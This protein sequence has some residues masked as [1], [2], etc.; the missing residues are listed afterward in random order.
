MPGHR[1]VLRPQVGGGPD[2]VGNDSDDDDDGDCGKVLR[3]D[4]GHLREQHCVL[5]QPRLLLLSLQ[6][7]IRGLGGGPGGDTGAARVK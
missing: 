4:P 5:Q 6:H 3:G 7:R 2:D 1:R